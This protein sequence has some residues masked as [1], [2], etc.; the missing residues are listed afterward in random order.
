MA[1]RW[2]KAGRLTLLVVTCS[3][4]TACVHRFASVYVNAVLKST[5]SSVSLDLYNGQSGSHLGE[6][7]TTI[8]LKRS[9]GTKK[10]TL[11]LLVRGGI[12]GCP[13]YWQIVAVQNWGKSP[14]EAQTSYKKNEVLFIVDDEN[15]TCRR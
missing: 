6:T 12:N 14:E 10:P 9:V 3:A 8:L 1:S 5:H 7:P 2:R 4:T 11:S 13:T 15:V